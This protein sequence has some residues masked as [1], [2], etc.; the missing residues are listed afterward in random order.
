MVLGYTTTENGD[1]ATDK[2]KK[3]GNNWYYLDSDGEM[4][5]DTAD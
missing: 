2:W 1:R 3:S 4:A 5:I